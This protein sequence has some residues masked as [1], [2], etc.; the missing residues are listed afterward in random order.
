MFSLV[1]R[2]RRQYCGT[3][4]SMNSKVVRFLM[5]RQAEPRLAHSSSF[6]SIFRSSTSKMRVDPPENT[7]ELN[8]VQQK[9]HQERK[10]SLKL[11]YLTDIDAYQ[12][13]LY[14]TNVHSTDDMNIQLNIT[15]R[16]SAKYS[17]IQHCSKKHLLVKL[18]PEVARKLC[19]QPIGHQNNR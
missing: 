10:T 9:K 13:K 11:Y 8:I 17:G 2:R 18:Y 1:C 16:Y 7:V 4:A 12:T 19:K 5:H 15:F 14:K 6:R 3:A